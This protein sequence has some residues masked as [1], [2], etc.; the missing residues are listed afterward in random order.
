MEAEYVRKTLEFF[1]NLYLAL[2]QNFINLIFEE[3][4]V[5]DFDCN[6][7]AGLVMSAFVDV[8]G[9]ALADDIVETVAV[10]LDLLPCEIVG[11]VVFCV[12]NN[13]IYLFPK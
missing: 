11:H 3:A 12:K 4:Q 1:Q 10:V 5:N 8:A 2:E 13:N 9:V 7:L 6:I